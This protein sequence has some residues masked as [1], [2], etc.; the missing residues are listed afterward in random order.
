MEHCNAEN[1]P[2]KENHRPCDTKTTFYWR[3]SIPNDV[4]LEW[5]SPLLEGNIVFG[6]VSATDFFCCW[7]GS[8]GGRMPRPRIS[9]VGPP[10]TLG[11]PPPLDRTS[12][13]SSIQHP[14]E[15]LFLKGAFA[16]NHKFLIQKQ[17]VKKVPTLKR[18]CP[19]YPSD[20]NKKDSSSCP[21]F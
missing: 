1:S 14:Q 12:A 13:H 11:S 2:R 8:G 4:L 20:L 18:G 21:V 15:G 6:S 3:V 16:T 7:G 10:I 19:G 5:D 9:I 17:C